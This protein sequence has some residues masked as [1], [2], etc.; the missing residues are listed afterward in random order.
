MR[1]LKAITSFILHLIITF[2]VNKIKI[3]TY[4][5]KNTTMLITSENCCTT[6]K[7]NKY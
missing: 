5:E 6:V 3:V 1:I 7:Y 2:M 4:L